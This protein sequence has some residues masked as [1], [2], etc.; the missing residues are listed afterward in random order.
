MNLNDE[1]KI[2]KLTAETTWNFEMWSPS[3][4]NLLKCMVSDF[5]LFLHG[6][7][8]SDPTEVLFSGLCYRKPI[9][10]SLFASVHLDFDCFKEQQH[11]L[12]HY[13]WGG[14]PVCSYA[15]L[16][17][18]EL[19]TIAVIRWLKH[20]SIYADSAFKLTLF[21]KLGAA[22]PRELLTSLFLKYMRDHGYPF[23]C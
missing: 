1:S 8:I 20:D 18:E 19:W 13:C 21:L 9:S 2:P 10:V 14:H 6:W 5:R 17:M 16:C 15:M 4:C 23:P 11:Y 12:L 3:S 22:E 7:A